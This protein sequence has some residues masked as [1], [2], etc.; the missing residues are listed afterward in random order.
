MTLAPTYSR[1]EIVDRCAKCGDV[2]VHGSEHLIARS[3]EN[4]AYA[5]SGVIV[6]DGESATIS[7]RTA[8]RAAATLRF[9]NRSILRAGQPELDT[10]IVTPGS[11]RSFRAMNLVPAPRHERDPAGYA[12]TFREPEVYRSGPT[13]SIAIAIINTDTL[14]APRPQAVGPIRG[15]G[16]L[17]HRLRCLAAW[18]MLAVHTNSLPQ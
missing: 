6:V 1:A 16:V 18:A 17:A 10:K 15:R 5:S 14:P 13:K 8:D 3:T 9:E 4:P 11:T 2:L 12:G 7:R